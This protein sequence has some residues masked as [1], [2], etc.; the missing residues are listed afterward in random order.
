MIATNAVSVLESAFH[1]RNTDPSL[2]IWLVTGVAVVTLFALRGQYD[3]VTKLPQELVVPLD[4]W[5]NALMDL[6]VASFKWLFRAISRFFEWPMI[7]LQALLHWL[8]W[9]TPTGG[10]SAKLPPMRS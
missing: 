7:G 6:F 10:S 2:A 5:L 8:P 9:P 4:A 1:R 3:W